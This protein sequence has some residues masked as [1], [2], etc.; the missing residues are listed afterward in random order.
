MTQENTWFSL[1]KILALKTL[2]KLFYTLED[3]D[4][5]C[6]LVES[7]SLKRSES[8]IEKQ[9]SAL[10]PLIAFEVV[11]NKCYYILAKDQWYLWG[12]KTENYFFGLEQSIKLNFLKYPTVK[13]NVLLCDDL[14]NVL[15]FLQIGVP[16]ILVDPSKL[17]DNHYFNQIITPTFKNLIVTFDKKY[18]PSSFR[19]T[20]IKFFDLKDQSYYSDLRTDMYIVGTDAILESI[21]ELYE[22]Y[23][24]SDLLD[25]EVQVGNFTITH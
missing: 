2:K 11:P 21:T 13:G 10:V 18:V 12:E 25:E 15:C 8:I 22:P 1:N 14:I 19:A 17:W 23:I 3:I 24:D 16:A 4:Y 9:F 5:N 7:F 20:S 6:R